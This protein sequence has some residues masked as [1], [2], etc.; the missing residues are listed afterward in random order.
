MRL[1]SE[2]ASAARDAALAQRGDGAAPDGLAADL[3]PPADV[4]IYLG[5]SGRV[6]VGP[7]E[8]TSPTLVGFAV[9]D[10][11]V[12]PH[13]RASAR[14]CTAA[15]VGDMTSRSRRR[16]ARGDRS[17]SPRPRSRRFGVTGSDRTGSAFWPGTAGRI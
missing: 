17:R 12:D 14:R 3:L 2:A 10:R 5:S 7:E 16:R 15:R 8:S 1:H 4:G 11:A 13:Q 6:F 9:V